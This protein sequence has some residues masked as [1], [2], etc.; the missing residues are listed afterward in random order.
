MK[1]KLEKIQPVFGSS[2]TLR[3]FEKHDFCNTP[4]WHF[5]P[6]YEIV[7]ISNGKG[8]RHIGDHISY[9]EDGDLIFLGPDLPHFGFTEKI[10][11]E[12]LEIVLQMKEDFMG[13]EFLSKPE[14]HQIAQLF[15]RARQGIIFHGA[16]KEEAGSILSRMVRLQGFPRFM[17]LLELLHLLATSNEYEILNANSFAFEVNSQDYPRIQAIYSYVE[18]NFKEHISLDQMAKKVN[19]TPPAFSRYFKRLTGKTFIQFVNEY[20]IAYACKQLGEEDLPISEISFESGFNNISHF[21]KQFKLITGE[22][23]RNYRKNLKKVVKA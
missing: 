17:G 9:Y 18:S 15:D 8:K 3:A 21:N 20:R 10:M 4:F 13:P 11:E 19:M 16:T 1:A 2:F 12:H 5:H 6:E 22:T 7:Y 14:M 23:P